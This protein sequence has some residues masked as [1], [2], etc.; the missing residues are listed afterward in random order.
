M[1]K[2]SASTLAL[3]L[4]KEKGIFGLY[5]GIGPTIARDITFS[6]I[7]FPLFAQL[8]SLVCIK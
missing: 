5:K 8:N 1:L 3:Q 7:Y 2:P 4:L 6:I